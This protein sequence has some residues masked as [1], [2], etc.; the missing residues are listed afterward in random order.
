MDLLM[1]LLDAPA[2]DTTPAAPAAESTNKVATPQ[3][4]ATNAALR[5]IT[6]GSV[7][8]GKSTLIGRLLVDSRSVLQDQ[9]ANVSRSGA[10]D[11][12]QFTDGLTAE[13]EQGIT[14]DVASAISPLHGASSSS[15]TRPATSSTRAT[16]SLPP[17]APTRLWCWLMQPS[18]TGTVTCWPTR[19]TPCCRRRGATACW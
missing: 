12:A 10:V 7:D 8:D 1:E 6:C 11:L 18:C 17:A 19:P 9:L 14:I 13:R 5:F 16:W 2:Q 4:D 3:G 15:E